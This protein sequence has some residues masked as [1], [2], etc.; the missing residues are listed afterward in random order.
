[1]AVPFV[2]AGESM[3]VYPAQIKEV[4][5]TSVLQRDRRGRR[6]AQKDEPESPKFQVFQAWD[7][8]GLPPLPPGV[9]Q[10]PAGQFF[11]ADPSFSA[12]GINRPPPP[13]FLPPA[14]Q[15]QW[16][17]AKPVEYGQLGQMADGSHVGPPKALPPPVPPPPGCDCGP[18]AFKDLPGLFAKVK[19]LMN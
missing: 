7:G 6:M 16:N 2:H 15:F 18:N 17:S 19:V 4:V 3:Q 1:M 13:M 8:V 12:D 9:T 5:T 10:P 11:F 14:S